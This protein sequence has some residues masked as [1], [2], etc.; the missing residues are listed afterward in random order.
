GTAADLDAG[1][2]RR[3][4]GWHTLDLEPGTLFHLPPWT[5]H[6][7]VC[8]RRSLALSLTWRRRDARG[9]RA[10]P[11]RRRAGLVAWDV[12]SGGVDALPRASRSRLWTQVPVAAGGVTRGSFELVTPDG[13][14]RLPAGARRVAAHLAS[15]PSI[16]ARKLA[17]DREALA[18]LA[19]HGILAPHDL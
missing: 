4:A 19:A 8:H 12:V 17:R 9:R 6:D 2:V 1:R 3:G 10:T 5:P 15:M 16:A 13:I 18:L 11:A 7:V 14:L